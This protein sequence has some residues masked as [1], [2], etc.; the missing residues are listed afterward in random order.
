LSE[1]FHLRP[2]CRSPGLAGV[3]DGR[4]QIRRKQKCPTKALKDSTR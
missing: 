1:T 4:K 3:F 2:F